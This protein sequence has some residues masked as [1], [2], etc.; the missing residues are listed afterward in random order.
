MG[1]SPTWPITIRIPRPRGPRT[2]IWADTDPVLLGIDDEAKNRQLEGIMTRIGEVVAGVQEAKLEAGR[3]TRSAG[4]H[5]WL[6]RVHLRGV[7][8]ANH[9]PDDRRRTPC[10]R[11]RAHAARR[12]RPGTR[13]SRRRWP[14]RWRPRGTYRSSEL[15]D[16]R[17][18][19]APWLG[20]HRAIEPHR[21]PVSPVQPD[22]SGMV[23]QHFRRT[24][25]LRRP[26]PGKPSR[27]VI[28]RWSSRRQARAKRW[29]PS[30]GRWTASPASQERPTGRPAPA[31]STCPP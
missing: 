13:N 10:R 24:H 23:R 21:R 19:L 4:H 1:C 12:D 7:P 28:T 16:C 29:P 2:S 8:A 26:A 18:P 9:R 6:D 5:S 15:V 14:R 30:C 22:H 20:G 17:C 31:C 25:R 3:R 27:M 11:M